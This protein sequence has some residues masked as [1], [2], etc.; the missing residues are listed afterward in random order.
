MEIESTKL[1]L[2]LG[3]SMI[4]VLLQA[5][6]AIVL[7]CLLN[8]DSVEEALRGE[9]Q[10]IASYDV[11][12]HVKEKRG[13]ARQ[14]SNACFFFFLLPHSAGEEDL[15][16]RLAFPIVIGHVDS[17]FSFNQTWWAPPAST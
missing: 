5:M 11:I 16:N 9:D 13:R 6:P 3:R 2:G 10:I 15:T 12:K 7:G 14:N 1:M 17:F 4:S 8:S